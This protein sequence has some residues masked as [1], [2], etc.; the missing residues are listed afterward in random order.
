LIPSE[1]IDEVARDRHRKQ[2]K[3]TGTFNDD[4]LSVRAEVYQW[5]K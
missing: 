3:L 5:R 4:Q 2:L 1:Y